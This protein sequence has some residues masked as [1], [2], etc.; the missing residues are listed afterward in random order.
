MKCPYC[1]RNELAR[2]I[3]GYVGDIEHELIER[4]DL[5]LA[6]CVPDSYGINVEDKWYFPTRYC[7]KC[8]RFSYYLDDMDRVLGES[9]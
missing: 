5:Y 3:Y 9:P 7:N 2:V 1:E 8:K 4:K 6:G